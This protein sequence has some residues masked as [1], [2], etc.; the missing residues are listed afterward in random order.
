MDGD[1]ILKRQ[2]ALSVIVKKIAERRG[3]VLILAVS[4]IL[5]LSVSAE[6]YF[7]LRN[8]GT[9]IVTHWNNYSGIDR[10]GTSDDLLRMAFF[11]IIIVAA[12][13]ALGLVLE[14]RNKFAAWLV[15]SA[16]LLMS[17]LHFILFIAIMGVN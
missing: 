7:S 17:V 13:G 5:V 8:I 2:M 4:F 11:G 1:E 16:T 15:A 3:I 12:N 14:P 9:P 6:A 10:I